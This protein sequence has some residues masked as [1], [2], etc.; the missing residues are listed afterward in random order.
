MNCRYNWL[1]SAKQSTKDLQHLACKV[2]DYGGE[3]GTDINLLK[4]DK[5]AHVVSKTEFKMFYNTFTVTNINS[6]YETSHQ[7]HSN[8]IKLDKVNSSKL[9]DLI[10]Q[11]KAHQTK[12]VNARLLL[13]NFSVELVQYRYVTNFSWLSHRE[14]SKFHSVWRQKMRNSCRSVVPNTHAQEQQE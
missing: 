2:F 4:I 5:L 13:G 3:W 1:I 6:V 12:R 9:V 7:Q 10:Q 11:K 8:I 14:K